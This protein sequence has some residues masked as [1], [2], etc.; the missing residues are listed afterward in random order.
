MDAAAEDQLDLAKSLLGRG[1]DINARDDDEDNAL[2]YASSSA[3]ARLLLEA[4]IEA[5]YR[6]SAGVLRQPGLEAVLD[7]D[8]HELLAVLLAAPTTDLSDLSACNDSLIWGDFEDRLDA[9]AQTLRL[10]GAAG[11][12]LDVWDPETG[13]SLLMACVRDSLEAPALAV[14][15]SGA[16]LN[17][18]HKNTETALLISCG[19]SEQEIQARIT[20]ALL[21]HGADDCQRNFV[22]E[23]PWDQAAG[24]RHRKCVAALEQ[25]FERTRKDALDDCDWYGSDFAEHWNPVVFE[26]LARR[27]NL[28]TFRHWVRQGEH[29]IVRGLLAAGYPVN[30]PKH[31]LLPLQDAVTSGD[32]R[33]LE[34]L[35]ECGADPNLL[36]F[37]GES[38][39]YNAADTGQ[40]EMARALLAAGANPNVQSRD[41][42]WLHTPLICATMRGNVEMVRL[43]LAAGAD[44]RTVDAQGRSA[45]DHAG[46]HEPLRTLLREAA[47]ARP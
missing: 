9:R 16:D 33:M 12:D 3:M 4:G 21:A 26:A 25:V 8:D 24:F 31:G 32:Q 14:I 19:S 43:L 38:A 37:W 15:E 36:D 44:P 17:R 34:L 18:S 35:L 40:V 45:L 6:D 41:D 11:A 46:E 23:S 39:L 42:M 10:L 2:A 13:E 30:P 5:S 27:T 20:A 22:G 1:A 29:A 47:S 28:E 7:E